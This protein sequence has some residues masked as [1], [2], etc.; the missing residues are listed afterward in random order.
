MRI[1]I[2]A[3]GG[4]FGPET[5]V[6][7]AVDGAREHDTSILLTGRKDVI[8]SILCRLDIRGL[9]IEITDTPESV[10]MDESPAMAVRKKP[11]SSI[12]L[13]I[14]AIKSGDAGAMLSAGNS[15]AV[16]ASA[17][18]ALGRI[19]GIDRPALTTL[20]PSPRSATL[21]IDLGVVVEPSPQNLVEFAH[22]AKIYR[23]KTTGRLN[24]SIGLLSNGEE[25]G[26]GNAL[27]I[28]AHELLSAEPA[29]NFHGNVEGNDLLAGIVDIIVTDGFSG[30]IALK[31]VEGVI[32]IYT[33]LI[34]MR[35]REAEFPTSESAE[36]AQSALAEAGTIMDYAE[37]GGA[38]LLGVNGAVVICHGRSSR[39]AMASAVGMALSLA[40]LG[41]V[42][43]IAAAMAAR[44]GNLPASLPTG[45][46]A[47]QPEI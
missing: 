32:A 6:S 25:S 18:M 46:S 5:V 17:F 13:A 29:L 47:R 2:D 35:L 9:D 38:P 23:E 31:T 41:V 34:E 4:D 43:E 21:L 16:M 14:Q 37:I 44:T 24:P 19:P 26:K 39:R 12:N 20:L 15:G 7:G 10:E 1:A 22:M 30:N 40:K 28:Q 3:M 36:R 8:E 33:E 45:L 27:T 42:S 11:R